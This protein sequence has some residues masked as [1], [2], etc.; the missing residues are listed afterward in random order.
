MISVATAESVLRHVLPLCDRYYTYNDDLCRAGY[1]AYRLW[2]D[3]HESFAES[4]EELELHR[5]ITV[6]FAKYRLCRFHVVPRHESERDPWDGF[7]SP[8]D[9]SWLERLKRDVFGAEYPD[10]PVILATADGRSID[11]CL[12]R[13]KQL[14]LTCLSEWNARFRVARERQLEAQEQ[15][16]PTLGC[17]GIDAEGSDSVSVAK[18][19]CR[20]M[21]SLLGPLGFK[22]ARSS[23]ASTEFVKPIVSGYSIGISV[24]ARDWSLGIRSRDI[25]EDGTRW[26]V[27]N[28]LDFDLWLFEGK[29]CRPEFAIPIPLRH[30]SAFGI[31]DSF[32]TFFSAR[33]IEAGL[34]GAVF[35]LSLLLESL[36]GA[37]TAALRE[38]GPWSSSF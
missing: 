35:A 23:K 7:R 12:G 26:P 32:S 1:R 25:D 17:A 9:S 27:P 34:A 19:V 30:V 14:R 21:E 38:N 10:A 2:H 22:L 36:E 4:E 31:D 15:E 5:K 18:G 13:E 6:E 29:R 3:Y 8:Y 33:H 28:C 11:A 20:Y 16:C 37:I 24:S